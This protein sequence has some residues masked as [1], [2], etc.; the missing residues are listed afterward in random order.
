[1]FSGVIPRAAIALFE[2]LSGGSGGEKSSG[3][4]APV[5][6][7]TPLATLQRNN[8]DKGWTMKATYVEV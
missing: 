3:I 4:K 1:V 2:K 6:Y 8:P 7:S 5:R